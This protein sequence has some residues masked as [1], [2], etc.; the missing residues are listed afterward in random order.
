V[1]S[2][3]ATIADETD[4]ITFSWED[5]TSYTETYTS[6]TDNDS[7]ASYDLYMG[8]FPV[9]GSLNSDVSGPLYF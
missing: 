7:G 8:T 1:T 3:S 5:Y 6:F 4:C 9:S 2:D